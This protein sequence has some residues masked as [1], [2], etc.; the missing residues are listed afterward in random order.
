MKKLLISGVSLLAIIGLMAGC[1]G[2][3]ITGETGPR[4]DSLTVELTSD[5]EGVHARLDV[6]VS[7]FD[8]V[9]TISDN[10][11]DETQG[12]GDFVYYLDSVPS[13][14]QGEELMLGEPDQI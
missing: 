5:D 9:D 10:E 6:S 3:G 12:D 4:V 14:L 13:S 1:T 7:E 8:V 11:T 2:T